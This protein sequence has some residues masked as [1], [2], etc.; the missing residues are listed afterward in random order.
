MQQSSRKKRDL[1]RMTPLR[2]AAIAF[3]ER[4]YDAGFFMTSMICASLSSN[5]GYIV[6][7]LEYD[8]MKKQQILFG[9]SFYLRSLTLV[10]MN[11]FWSA[12]KNLLAFFKVAKIV[13]CVEGA[14]RAYHTIPYLIES[15]RR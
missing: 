1:V 6:F 13:P 5:D 7:S 8:A 14:A 12:N 11:V 3:M 15:N 9:I 10:K 2:F 4:L